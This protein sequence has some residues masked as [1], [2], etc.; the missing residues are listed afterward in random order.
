MREP[1]RAEPGRQGEIALLKEE[2]TGVRKRLSDLE[3]HVK[4]KDEKVA[5]LT[6]QLV[7]FSLKLTEKESLL[8]KNADNL[9]SLNQE[10]T[11]LYSRFE[12]GQRIL[13]GK[14]DQIQSLEEALKDVQLQTTERGELLKDALVS[15]DEELAEISGILQIYKGKLGDTTK[16]LR[17]KTAMLQKTKQDLAVLENRLLGIQEELLKF[18]KQQEGNESKGPG[19]TKEFLNLQS[20]LKAIQQFLDKQ[21]TEVEELDTA[22]II[23]RR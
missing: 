5:N 2:L 3:E 7:D 1:L 4:E 14:D 10:L 12:L 17:E 19:V 13:K 22:F 23:F 20:Q 21:L 15:K 6:E 11:D 16:K 8:T 18:R 9:T